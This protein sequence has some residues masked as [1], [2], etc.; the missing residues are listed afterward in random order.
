[1][2]DL[3]T[4]I[5]GPY[6]TQILADLGADVIKVEP[7]AGDNMRFAAPMKNRGM[8]HI[9][10]QLNRNKRGAVLDLKQPAGREAALRLAATA[11]VFVHNVRPAAM[12]RLGLSYEEV[13]AVRPDIVYVSA[14]GFRR[15]GPYGDKAAYDDIIQG[16]I[17]IPSLIADQ[18]GDR[19]R[20]VPA[21]I[22]DRITGLNAVNAVTA[23]LFARERTGRG[24]HVEVTMFETLTEFVLSDHLGGAAWEPPIGPVGYPRLLARD[25]NPYRTSDGYLALLIYNDRQWQSFFAAIDKP[26]LFAEEP[27][28]SQA[29]RS[30][31]IAEV[32][33]YVAR[34]LE[35]R[36]TADWIDL[37]ERAD[38][39]AMPLHT[40]DSLIHDPHL[41]AV[42][43]FHHRR[44]PS[45][46]DVLMMDAPSR[47]SATPPAFRSHA[48]L[49]GQHSV[50]VLAE[51]GYTEAEIERL[52]AD[53]VTATA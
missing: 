39:P 52:L 48:P 50:E 27:F 10:L 30:E 42:G 36:S 4:V 29:A 13:A 53:G 26:E 8:G 15:E 19:P 3:T 21:T 11:D 6:A 12:A 17:A 14:Y 31:N 24:Q 9:F 34:Q 49:L 16:L 7:P 41:E 23:A 28:S 38:I 22:C 25:R 1:V 40:L 44:H 43:F 5:L 18:T 33:A 37:F 2:L 51:A 20:F 45:E 47:W 32:Y 35:T 46:G